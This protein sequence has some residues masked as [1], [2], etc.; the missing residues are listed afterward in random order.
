[1]LAIQF[2][3]FVDFSIAPSSVQTLPDERRRIS[4]EINGW[5]GVHIVA[6]RRLVKFPQGQPSAV[7]ALLRSVDA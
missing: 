7:Q 1:M 3:Y 5:K 2:S 6:S 4:R